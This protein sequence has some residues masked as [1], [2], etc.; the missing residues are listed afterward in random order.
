V[1]IRIDEEF[2]R[3]MDPLQPEEYDQLKQNIISDGCRDPLVIWAEHGILVDG[4]NRYR[5][6][7]ENQI[8]F[9]TFKK[10]FEDRE[11]V[12]DWIDCA[13]AGR[14]N[15]SPD[16]LSFI[17]GR[18]YNR[19]KQQGVRTDLT[20]GQNVQKS[21]TTAEILAAQH[22]VNEKT[23]RRDGA[24][25]DDV[26]KLRG[27]VPEIESIVFSPI[28]SEQVSKAEIKIAA[29]LMDEH[30]EAAAAI[31]TKYNHRAIGTGENEWYTPIEYSEAAR[32]V[33]GDIDLD[34]ASSAQ[35]QE[36][37][38]ALNY[39]TIEENGLIQTWSGRVF[40][41]P[42][43]TQPDIKNF[44][45]KAVDE[46][47]AGNIHE[48]IILTHNYTD[49]AWFHLASSVCSAICFTRGRIAFVSPEG[50]KAAPTQGQTFFYYG[51]NTEAFKR[52]F[53]TIG[54]VLMR[55]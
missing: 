37:I 29:D 16:R 9:T 24:F 15:L 41:N 26:E 3:W 52:E 47:A 10:S 30:P 44:I 5:I 14:R 54:L 23:I 25:A 21:Q 36:T 34:P 22:G 13:Q 49:T 43:Y 55:Y 42:P 35:A 12:L 18:R 2:S 1:E 31:V 4:H 27:I 40:L 28:K 39:F 32:S 50:K 45:Q 19:Q 11:S 20:Y 51:K 17:R 33:M 8:P 38:R 53:S 6:C 7:L 48:A 46:F